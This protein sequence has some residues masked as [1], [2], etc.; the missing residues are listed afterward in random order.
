MRQ[1][2]FSNRFLMPA[3]S[4]ILLLV[5]IS[6][7]LLYSP[8]AVADEGKTVSPIQIR[9]PAADL[10]RE[11]RQREMEGVGS[12]QVSGVQSGVL[13]NPYGDHWRQ[14]RMQQ[15]LPVGGYLLVGVIGLV[16][17]F[18]LLHGR[19]RIKAG[20]SDRRLLRY[21]TYERM[22]HWFMAFIFL[23]LAFTGVVLL[24][25]RSLLLPW[26]GADLFSLLASASKEGH[27]LM[28]PL[29]LLA[30]LLVFIKFV[31]RNIYERGDLSWLLRGGG[32]IG[33]KPVPSNFFNMGEKSLFWMLIIVGSIIGA[34]GLVLVFPIFGQGRE[35]MELSH[36][37]HG[38]G[39]I[40]MLAVVIGHIYIGTIGME[41]AIEGMRDGYCDLNWALE[42]HDRWAK[43]CEGKGDVLDAEEVAAQR[44][45]GVSVIV[46]EETGK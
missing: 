1:I 46:A 12:S 37:A 17:I 35:I 6:L 25:G 30:L 33:K 22:I 36:V 26:M 38:I 29:F 14:F 27:N 40:A 28:G 34:S 10:W 24:F 7:L 15:L 41:G 20:V 43:K 9:N 11:V 2:H 8:V 13:I 4:V 19:V 21:S 5:L 23:F 45:E 16:I 42:H 3:L 32:I 18:H 44:G 39:A 31:R